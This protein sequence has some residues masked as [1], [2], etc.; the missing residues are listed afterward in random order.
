MVSEVYVPGSERG[1]LALS[2]FVTCHFAMPVL[3]VRSEH[4]IECESRV[5][6]DYRDLSCRKCQR[7]CTF[8]AVLHPYCR[9]S[10]AM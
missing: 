3:I 5:S 10:M 8:V 7:I 2:L 9:D 4:G 1:T 6:S